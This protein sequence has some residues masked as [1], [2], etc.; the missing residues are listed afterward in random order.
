MPNGPFVAEIDSPQ[1]RPVRLAADTWDHVLEGHP[2]MVDYLDET[3][4][5]VSAPD[6]QEPDIRRG[7]ERFFRQGGPQ[8]WIRVVTQFAGEADDV[9]TAFP[10]DNDPR[11]EA[12]NR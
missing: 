8:E 1:G 4:R 2:E 9:V 3:M 11:P 12:G 7:R 6:Y 10:Q 5:T